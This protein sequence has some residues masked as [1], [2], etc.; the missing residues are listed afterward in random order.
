M[1]SPQ[2]CDAL[3]VGAGVAGLTAALSL[4]EHRQIAV[5][6][7]SDAGASASYRAQGGIA[8]A[9]G[10]HD[11][12]ESHIADTLKVGC[13]LGHRDTVHRLVER[14]SEC[15]QWL[16]AQGMNFTR[17]DG[18]T[19]HLGREGGHSHRRVLH[20]DDATGRALIETLM[21]RVAERDNIRLFPEMLAVDL[22]VGP[23]GRCGGAHVLDI[24]SGKVLQFRA[25]TVL[26][27]CGGASRAYLYSTTPAGSFGDGIA[28]AWR[29][30]CRIGN[31]EFNQFHPTCLYHP[32]SDGLLISET[33]RGEGGK[34]LL[35][36]GDRFMR[37]FDERLELA[38][39]DIVAR[40]IDHE[41]KRLGLDCVYLD[42]SHRGEAFVRRHFPNIH[43]R[44][45]A[46]GIDIGRQRI[47]VVPGAHYSCGGIVVD[48]QGRA[49]LPGLYAA[50]ETAFTGVHGANRLASNSLLE[51][52]VYGRAAA[53]DMHSAIDTS[54]DFPA[55]QPWDA[56]RVT[57]SDEDVLLSHN[58]DEL[59]RC[60]WDYVGIVRNERRLLRAA[61][62]IE[63]MQREVQDYYA[64]YR[65]SRDLIELRNLLTV[66][67]LIV[68]SAL[69]RRESR[70]LHY[71]SDFPDPLPDARDTLLAPPG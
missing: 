16:E 60:M 28:I 1:H 18:D 66:S 43:R 59:R 44:C 56:S 70:G 64:H 65:I 12:V 35:P 62:R 47:P 3:I 48:A 24:G 5:I 25:R 14:G 71:R 4:P 52:L 15:I 6:C 58:W 34:L 9:V 38:P 19:L 32:G 63:I 37:R 45:L 69:L 29:A 67:E 21:A 31:M 50:G 17:L 53:V 55:P 20:V 30:G 26:L 27:A 46:L 7:K 10:E 23:D 54:Q 40:A 39:R 8:A 68:R 49:D 2:D 11:S 51:C 36:D 33:V 61:K 41:M 13:G 22:V 42:I 57:V